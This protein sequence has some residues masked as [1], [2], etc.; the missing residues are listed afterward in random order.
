MLVF[1]PTHGANTTALSL[2]DLIDCIKNLKK[3]FYWWLILPSPSARG[4]S[5]ERIA[6]GI[7]EKLG[8]K[9]LETNKAIIL[10]KSEAFEVDIL[11]QGPEGEKYCVEVKAGKAGVSDIR[12]V[13]ADSEI[14]GYKPLL[15]CKGYADEAAGEV[16]EKLGVKVIELS[17]YHLLLDP[18]ELEIIVR[19]AVQE[20]LT[21]YGFYPLPAWE[22]IK[23]R[24]WE[25]IEAIANSKSFE[26]AAQSLGMSTKDLGHKIGALREIGVFPTKG[27]SF[28]NLKKHAQQLVHRYSIIRKLERIEKTLNIIEKFLSEKK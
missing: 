25:I 4:R 16:A 11:A 5:S 26:E 13:Y 22:E 23:E 1:R 21:E 27:Q 18:E 2:F 8:Y 7:L 24:D 6:R 9:I 14:L 15:V 20:V 10:G 12:K 3:T 17:E 28:S 19:N